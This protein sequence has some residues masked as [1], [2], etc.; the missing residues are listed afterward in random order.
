VQRPR[1]DTATQYRA[2]EPRPGRRGLDG[3]S[4]DELE[5]Q[6]LAAVRACGIVPGER[7]EAFD[8]LAQVASTVLDAPIALVSVVDETQ[9]WFAARVGLEA[10]STGRDVS[11]CAFAIRRPTELFV[12]PDAR[13]DDRFRD[14]GLVTGPPHIRFYAGA[15]IRDP[16][17]V[18]LGSLCVIDTVPRPGG[19]SPEQEQV[20]RL[21]AIQV[22]QQ[23]ELLRFTAALDRATAALSQSEQ[24]LDADRRFLDAAL[25]SL[26]EGVVACDAAGR[27]TIF[28]AAAERLHGLPADAD[29]PAERWSDHYAIH[30]A[31]GV[32]PLPVDRLPLLRALAGEEVRDV[33]VV[34]APHGRPSALISCDATAFHDQDGSLLGA[35]VTMRD[36]TERRRSEIALRHTA[37]HDGLTGL[38]NRAR[39]DRRLEAALASDGWHRLGVCFVDLNDFKR[40]NDDLGHPTGDQVLVAVAGRLDQVVKAT[41]TVARYGGDEFVVLV[42]DVAS[43]DL[44][45]IAERLREAL[46]PPIRVGRRALPTSAAI[47]TAH[48]GADDLTDGR[49]LLRRADQRMYDD[50]PRATR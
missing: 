40:I 10:P 15:P 38:P 3:S 30:E 11:F 32:T 9:Q 23:L 48:A 21:L 16:D 1:P 25:A 24:Q 50:K 42:E 37:D 26:T 14:N 2:A 29:V 19:L 13:A 39:F 43:E 17:G 5:A 12:V 4:I 22:E 35:V 20:L 45:R 27:L 36:I 49:A 33:E 41:D 7:N 6:R 47:G 8:A 18:A 46:Q 34:I 31:D 44:P 28:N